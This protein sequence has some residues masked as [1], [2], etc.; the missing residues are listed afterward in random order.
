[1][2][3]A[4]A[5]ALAAAFAVAIAGCTGTSQPDPVSYTLRFQ[6]E[7]LSLPVGARTTLSM[8]A[9]RTI[10]GDV[11]IRLVEWSLDDQTVAT[12]DNSQLSIGSPI[13]ATIGVTCVKAGQT[14]VGGS[15]TLNLD[16]RVSGKT[17]VTCTASP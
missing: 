9:S 3:S 1:M 17:S 6:P 11:D 2:P 5:R 14:S 4:P 16:N 12:L 15:V 13:Y 10:G 7:S 8:F